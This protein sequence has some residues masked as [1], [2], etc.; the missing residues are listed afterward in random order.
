MTPSHDSISSS[1]SEYVREIWFYPAMTD[2]PH[3]LGVFL[4]AEFYLRNMD[5]LSILAGLQKNDLVPQM[6]YIFVSHR[7]GEA[8]HRDYVCN[9]RYANFIARDVFDWAKK[10]ANLQIADHLVGGL[11]LSG[12]QSAFIAFRH[13]ELFSHALCQSGSFWWLASNDVPLPPTAAKFWLSVGDQETESGVSHPPTG[14]FQR[15][16]QIAGVDT[17]VQR[18]ASL[19]GTVRYQPYLGGHDPARWREELGPALEWL[20]SDPAKP[21]S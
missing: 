21:N 6:S 3:R 18:F 20:L 15:V 1:S 14:L 16:S 10:R 12:L 7:D 2:E 9:E 19:G 5:C 13:P 4:D 17:A 8:R 11:S